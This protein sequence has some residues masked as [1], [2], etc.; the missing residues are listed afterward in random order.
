MCFYTNN[1]SAK[2]DSDK[3]KQPRV[4]TVKCEGGAAERRGSNQLC[5]YNITLLTSFRGL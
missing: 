4:K 3:K 5:K 1:I 2:Q